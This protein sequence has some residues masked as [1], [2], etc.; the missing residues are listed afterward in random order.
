MTG[1]LYRNPHPWL[2]YFDPPNRCLLSR[3]E[4]LVSPYRIDPTLKFVFILFYLFIETNT[5]VFEPFVYIFF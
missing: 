5:H 4:L 3:K 2:V 1:T